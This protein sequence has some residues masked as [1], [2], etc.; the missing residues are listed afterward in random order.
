MTV[1]RSHSTASLSNYCIANFGVGVQIFDAESQMGEPLCKQTISV[2]S[3]RPRQ[4]L[5]Y[6]QGIQMA[7]RPPCEIEDISMGTPPDICLGSPGP[8]RGVCLPAF[9]L[10]VTSLSCLSLSSTICSCVKSFLSSVEFS[11]LWVSTTIMSFCKR[12]MS[13]P[14]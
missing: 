8:L 9:A 5:E 10:C 11:F 13:F 7:G 6:W 1:N 2:E 3:V 4:D 12:S 14:C